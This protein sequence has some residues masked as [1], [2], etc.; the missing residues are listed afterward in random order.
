MIV[1]TLLGLRPLILPDGKVTK[2]SLDAPQVVVNILAEQMA[3]EAYKRYSKALK[4]LGGRGTA[5]Q[6]MIACKGID[7]S[8]WLLNHEGTHVKR[9]GFSRD[10][11]RGKPRQIWAWISD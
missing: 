1:A 11:K 4:K 9:D 3:D 6:I 10:L 8:K 2:Y 7:P 5:Q